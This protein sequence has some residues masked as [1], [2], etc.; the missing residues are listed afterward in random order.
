MK[1]LEVSAGTRAGE[2]L[3]RI[4]SFAPGAI[5]VSDDDAVKYL[6]EPHF[7]NGPVP[8]VFNGVNWSATRSSST[9]RSGSICRGRKF[10]TR[11]R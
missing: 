11:S 2:A 9:R 10:A 1:R 3:D 7:K 5:V 4:R 8:V 6:F